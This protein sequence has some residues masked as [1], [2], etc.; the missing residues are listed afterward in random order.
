MAREYKDQILDTSVNTKRVYN[1]VDSD[2]NIVAENIS[3]EDKTVYSQE[4]TEFG[5][6]EVNEIYKA[7]DEVNSSLNVR[8]DP[9]T[10]YIQ[11]FF[12][13]NWVNVVLANVNIKTR[14]IFITNGSNDIDNW[15][16]LK[17]GA[18]SAQCLM[19]ISNEKIYQDAQGNSNTAFIYNEEIDFSKFSKLHVKYQVT[20]SGTENGIGTAGIGI[21]S[22]INNDMNFIDNYV[23][24]YST[25]SNTGILE[26][27]IDISGLNSTGYIKASCVHSSSYSIVLTVYNIWLEV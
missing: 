19:T 16:S 3:F 12:N 6:K 8:Y 18:S 26:K 15:L 24:K 9:E 17:S 2:G 20:W 5:A 4:G 21:A 23:V 7:I 1:I 25:L 22:D 14:D 11:A 27:T 13:D 10:D